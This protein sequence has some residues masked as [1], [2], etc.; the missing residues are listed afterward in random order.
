MSVKIG[1]VAVSVDGPYVVISSET[2]YFILGSSIDEAIALVECVNL[3]RAGMREPTFSARL[4]SPDDAVPTLNA[5]RRA[6]IEAG[7]WRRG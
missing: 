3:Y 2:E 5:I 6:A 7:Q 1:N 4:L